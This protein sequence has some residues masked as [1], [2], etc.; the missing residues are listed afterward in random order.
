MIPSV[1]TFTNRCTCNTL[2][3]FDVSVYGVATLSVAI[4]SAFAVS[5]LFLVGFQNKPI[6]K[7][8]L[9]G[10]MALGY[11]SMV[12]DACLHLIPEVNMY[13]VILYP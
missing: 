1:K 10:M 6:Y 12:G 9:S 4:I 2:P 8:L 3:I 5:G 7:Y 11:S 13:F